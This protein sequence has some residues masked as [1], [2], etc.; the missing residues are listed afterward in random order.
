MPTSKRSPSSSV[1]SNK[2]IGPSVHSSKPA[3][4]VIP[5]FKS[6]GTYPTMRFVPVTATGHPPLSQNQKIKTQPKTKTPTV[7]RS[8]R[9]YKKIKL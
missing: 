1:N 4:K 8:T 5:P 6:T 2:S 7:L 9:Q 3:P